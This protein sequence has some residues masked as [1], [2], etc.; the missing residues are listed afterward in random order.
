MCEIGAGGARIDEAR[1]VRILHDLVGTLSVSGSERGA[2][3]VFVRHAASLG[4][5]AGIDSAGN[6]VAR[7]SGGGAVK[8]RIALLGHI[9][10]VP[11]ELPVRIEN[12]VL[13]GRG[14]VD[15]KGPL[16]AMLV[17][18]A[19]AE[20]EDGVEVLVIAAVGEE[21]ASSP[22][23]RFVRDQFRPDACIIG[24]PSGW[25]GVTLG[26]KGR[27]VVT[28]R[29][30]QDG[31]HSA[32][33][34]SSPGDVL[35]AWWRRVIEFVDGLNDG[36]SRVFDRLQA[37][38][39]GMRSGGDGVSSWAEMSAGFRLPPRLDPKDLE[40]RVRGYAE[41]LGVE[42]WFDGHEQAHATTRSDPVVGALSAA[43]R[44][45]GGEARHKLKTGTADLNV[46]APV[47]RCPIA[48]YGPGDSALDHTPREHLSL[49]EYLRSTRVLERAVATLS[50]R[51]MSEPE[52][53]SAQDP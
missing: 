52:T 2:V 30:V 31:A 3:E 6:G 49:D 32:G 40:H 10:T 16:A 34:E 53:R 20:L 47:W 23:A 46:V 51:L 4:M 39:S 29:R 15:A 18:G 11:G 48:A 1:R 28:A 36:R 21:T 33:P 45:E 37:T 42:A 38:V 50:H 13:H 19:S 43:I 22:G 7:R 17:A 8:R 41:E 27:L 5:R 35:V 9:D 44:A 26:Y 14:S 24:E 25:D 12:G